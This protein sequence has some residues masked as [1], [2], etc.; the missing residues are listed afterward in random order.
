MLNCTVSLQIIFDSII[1]CRKISLMIT[2]TIC[3]CLTHFNWSSKSVSLSSQ[4]SFK[5]PGSCRFTLYSRYNELCLVV[6]WAQIWCAYVS[7]S[8][9]STE[10]VEIVLC[11]CLTFKPNTGCLILNYTTVKIG[12]PHHSYTHAC[13][14]VTFQVLYHLSDTISLLSFISHC[15]ALTEHLRTLYLLSLSL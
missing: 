13:K 2:W 12:S 4:G 11:C 5:L 10:T 9:Y 6:L 1:F 14:A 15:L 8:L 7:K 3:T